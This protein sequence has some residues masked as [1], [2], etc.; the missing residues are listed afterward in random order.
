MTVQEWVKENQGKHLCQCGCKQFILI[1]R[2]HRYYGIPRFIHNHDRKGKDNPAFIDGRTLKEDY[3]RKKKK[4]YS[5][6]YSFY[7]L[8]GNLGIPISLVFS[9]PKL[10]KML[11]SIKNLKEVIKDAFN[12]K[13]GKVYQ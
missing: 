13:R 6:K 3:W 9:E 2:H 11:I 12:E 8:A 1:K 5:Q 7:N 4:E 10:Q